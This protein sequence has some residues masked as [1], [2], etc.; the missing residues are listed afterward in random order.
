MNWQ[1]NT[2]M[3]GKEMLKWLVNVKRFYKKSILANQLFFTV[4]RL[5]LSF[6]YSSCIG[7]Y[8]LFEI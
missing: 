6:G 5:C 2:K 7:F 4:S 3:V 8:I 1:M